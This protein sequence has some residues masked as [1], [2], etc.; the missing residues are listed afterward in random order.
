MFDI[1]SF[2]EARD[3]KDA[4]E[5]LVREPEA[6]IISGGTDVLI[7][8]REGKDAGR[9]LVSI[10]NIKEL[11]GVKVL[12]NGDLWIG[13]ATAFS[14]ITND[15][16]IQKLVPM[17]GEAVD[18]VGGPQ[19]RN[20]GTIGGNI[21]NGATSAD[22]AA[23]MWTLNALIQLEGPEGHR[24]VPIHEFYTGPGRTVRDRCEV[25]T[26]F[27]IKKEDYEGWYGQYIKYG[28]RKA[29]EIATLGCAVRVKLSSDKKTIED[30][31]LGYGVAGPTPL[32][33]HA[34]EEYLRGKAVSDKEAAAEFAKLAL[35]EV[36]PRSS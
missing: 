9:A 21:C 8:V 15:P 16:T 27:I 7:R 6:E 11:K 4:V 31:R 18:M 32:R 33:C 24:E 23:S 35:T 12:E 20:T 1:K 28:K 36:N 26:G 22:S 10:H 2:Y 29:M 3:V 19:I 34:A 25:C 13:S 17:L 14:H 30:V 5:A